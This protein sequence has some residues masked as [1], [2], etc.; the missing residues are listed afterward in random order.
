MLAGLLLGVDEL[1]VDPDLVHPTAAG[2]QGPRRDPILELRQDLFR[3]TGGARFVASSR[4]VE[5]FDVHHALLGSSPMVSAARRAGQNERLDTRTNVRYAR[6]VTAQPA[7]V[8]PPRRPV[9]ASEL[10]EHAFCRR[11]WWLRHERG[12]APQSAARWAA[13]RAAHARH[14]HAVARADRAAR[15]GWLVLALG[16]GLLVLGL[17]G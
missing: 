10:G 1:A 5:H 16:V 6:S 14:G 7:P 4:A 12:V 3:Q 13:G 2:D 11:A 8:E 17:L 15:L 9:R